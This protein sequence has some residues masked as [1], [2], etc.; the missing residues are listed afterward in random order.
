MNLGELR[1]RFR[2]R[3][4]DRAE[5]FLWND[6]EVRDFLNEAQDDVAV[7]TFCFRDEVTPSL[8]SIT[9]VPG[10][11]RYVLD[12]RVIEVA[13][14]RLVNRRLDLER[15]NDDEFSGF[16]GVGT[17]NEY[18]VALESPNR[19]LVL[20]RPPQTTP[21]IGPIAL[22]V[23][24]TALNRM[25]DDA[26]LC[27]LPAEWQMQMLHGAA[28]LAWNTPNSDASNGRLMKDAEDKFTA[29]FGQRP[30][31]ATIRRRLKHRGPISG[32]SPSLTYADRLRA[33]RYNPSASDPE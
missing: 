7:R 14:A 6:D 11:S 28:A 31:A 26:D 2:T 13:H 4:D 3:V 12:P 16:R 24:R 25:V 27:E 9:P 8:C 32:A 18:A 21:P 23:Y 30:N 20:D 19:V 29:Y 22:T 33:S 17:P 1:A 15:T 5:P 10:Q